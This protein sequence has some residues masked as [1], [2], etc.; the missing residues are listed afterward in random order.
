MWSINTEVN[1]RILTV[2]V[3]G[4]AVSSFDGSTYEEGM[5]RLEKAMKFKADGVEAGRRKKVTRRL[6]QYSEAF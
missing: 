5:L 1:E 6:E 2:D 3:E 4:S